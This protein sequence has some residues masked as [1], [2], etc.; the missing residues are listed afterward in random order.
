MRERGVFPI[1]EG[2]RRLTSDTADLFGMTDRG[3]LRP[4]S[5]ADV[6]VIDLDQLALELP[7]YV[8]D[9]PGGAGRYVQRAKGYRTTVV[10]GRVSLEDG[11][12]HRRP[13][14]RRCSASHAP[15]SRSSLRSAQTSGFV[16]SGFSEHA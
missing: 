7:E 16:A 10:N 8:H 5:F 14:R 3:V 9:F 15:D 12:P 11:R 1:E 6:N 4:G 13:R 2:V